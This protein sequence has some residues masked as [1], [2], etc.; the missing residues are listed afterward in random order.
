MLIVFGLV[1]SQGKIAGAN[2]EIAQDNYRYDMEN[3]VFPEEETFLVENEAPLRTAVSKKRNVAMFTATPMD[4]KKVEA[5][6]IAPSPEKKEVVVTEKKV[7]V[8]FDINKSRIKR[9]EREKLNAVLS[10][11]IKGTVQVIGYTCPLGPD[12]FNLK[13]AWD[14]AR[15]VK[16]YLGK[17]LKNAIVEEGKPK[18]C[19][20]SDTHLSQ[21]RRV[22]IVFSEDPQTGSHAKN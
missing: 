22:E 6:G 12:S 1:L 17:T 14:R 15:R 9:K 5:V 3:V 10:K 16:A 18:C 7:V 19:Y 20:V 13:L 21:N 4:E 11:D 2:I 8:H